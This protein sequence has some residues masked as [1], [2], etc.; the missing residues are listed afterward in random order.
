MRHFSAC[1]ISSFPDSCNYFF[2]LFAV[3]SCSALITLFVE[4]LLHTCMHNY[5]LSLFAVCIPCISSFPCCFGCFDSIFL[6]L[7]F[8]R[9]SSLSPL[10]MLNKTQL[11]MSLIFIE[12]LSS[13]HSDFFSRTQFTSFQVFKFHC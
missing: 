11:Y 6:A 10:W 2:S 1:C 12:L 9:I 8:E 3:F 5:S 7:G 13:G 4:R